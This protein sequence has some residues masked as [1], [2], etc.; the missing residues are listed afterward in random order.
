MLQTVGLGQYQNTDEAARRYRQNVKL[1][2]IY[3]TVT[4]DINYGTHQPNDCKG[5]TV[6][7]KE[8]FFIDQFHYILP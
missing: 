8:I 5:L 2:T 1:G 7:R 6:Y 3:F 4:N